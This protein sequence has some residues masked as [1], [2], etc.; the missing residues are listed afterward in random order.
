[1]K[2]NGTAQVVLA[3][4]GVMS[5]STQP[6]VSGRV[7][8]TNAS[9]Q[10]ARLPKPITNINIISEFTRAKTKQEFKLEKFSA[11]WATTPSTRR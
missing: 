6:D 7:S 5:D 9:I 2:G 10:Y 3:I 8:S 4:T 11:T 1:V